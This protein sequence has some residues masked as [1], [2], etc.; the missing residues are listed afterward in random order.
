MD[1]QLQAT[2]THLFT[3]KASQP[4]QTPGT[5]WILNGCLLNEW[6]KSLLLLFSH[7]VVSDSLKLHG[8][9][10]ARLPCPSPVCSNSCPLS[11]WFHPI[12]SSSC[13]L[14]LLPSIF[15]RIRVFSSQSTLWIRIQRPKD[16]SFSFSISPS[17]EYS[18][19]ISYRTNWFDLLAV[20]ETLNSLQQD[21][22]K[23]QFFSTQYSLWSNPHIC[24][25]LLEKP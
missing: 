12:I 9:Q 18:V 19:L 16:W 7:S 14:L 3:P 10:H 21:S 25:W 20:Q 5:W 22:L 1:S 11:Q 2:G 13:P 23:D 24:T 6:K 17:S 8:L 15:P 4:S